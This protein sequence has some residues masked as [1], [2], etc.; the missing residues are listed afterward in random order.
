M[1]RMI[2]HGVTVVAC[3]SDNRGMPI[4]YTQCGGIRMLKG[5]YNSAS[6]MI[7]Q[8]KKQ[9]ITAN[10]ISNSSTPGF[11]KDSVFLK[12][13]DEAQ[14]VAL[15]RQSDWEI[16]MIDRTYTDF[17]QGGFDNTGND[18]DTAISGDG[19]FVLESPEGG[20]RLYTRNGNFSI[21]L[22]GFLVNSEGY[23]VLGDGGPITAGGGTVSISEGGEVS[24]DNNQVGRLSVVAFPD[25][26]VLS[27]AGDTAF[28]PGSGVEPQ[29][30]TGYSI[31]QGYLERANTD[32]VKEM[33]GMIT[34][35]RNFESNSKAIQI[36]DSSLD[37]L[38]NQVGK[39]RM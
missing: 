5:I 10:N 21:D 13:L 24:V 34:T 15:P 23:R 30:A 37:A 12:E 26:S 2:G 35:Y 39:T 11:K 33:V 6:A 1:Y 31:R 9:E 17:M 18:L 20:Q 14:Q 8:I 32:V 7:P 28:V 3:P 16:P 4:A 22:E 25:K 36:Q 19:F 27:K 38:F 29:A